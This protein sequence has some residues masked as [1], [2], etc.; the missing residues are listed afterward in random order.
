L[1]RRSSGPHRSKQ[2]M[3]GGVAVVVECG[4]AEVA[5]LNP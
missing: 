3:V 2:L 4:A 1:S 5:L